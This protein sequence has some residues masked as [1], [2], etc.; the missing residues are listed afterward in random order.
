[1]D[2]DD[3]LNG[4][5][6]AGW[7]VVDQS[8][9]MTRAPKKPAQQ[10]LGE[11]VHNTPI[12]TPNTNIVGEFINVLG[13]RPVQPT[14]T[15]PPPMKNAALMSLVNTAPAM[16]LSTNDIITSSSTGYKMWQIGELPTPIDG[17]DNVDNTDTP[18]LQMLG[19]S[20]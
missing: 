11:V 20:L 3:Y 12:T 8:N 9:G 18:Y 5:Q 10:L 13:G 1:M 4:I 7:T 15:T 6:V 2:D 19:V 17:W 14:N 16:A